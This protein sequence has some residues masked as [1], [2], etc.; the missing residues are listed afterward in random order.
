[1]DQPSGVL[2]YV[3]Y[4]LPEFTNG[5]GLPSIVV[6]PS[7]YYG[8]Y[9]SLRGYCKSGSKLPI[10]RLLVTGLSGRSYNGHY[11]NRIMYL[12]IVFSIF[13]RRVWLSRWLT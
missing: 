1:M 13:G 4:S 3:T 6:D 9:P 12:Y 8:T 10:N 5:M 11:L 2:L 7:L